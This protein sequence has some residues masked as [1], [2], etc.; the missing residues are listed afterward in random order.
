MTLFDEDYCLLRRPE[1]LGGDTMCLKDAC[2]H[3]MAA[4]SEGRMTAEGLLQCVSPLFPLSPS[5]LTLPGHKHHSRLKSLCVPPTD[6][7]I[8]RIMAGA[9]RRTAP[10]QTSPPPQG[11]ERRHPLEALPASVKPS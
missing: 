10:A 4:L 11:E 8:R 6:Q 1:A 5:P 2:P 9:L 7:P 3:R